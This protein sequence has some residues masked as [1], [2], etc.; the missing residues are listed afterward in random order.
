[1]MLLL[2]YLHLAGFF[3]F[4][5]GRIVSGIE[6]HHLLPGIIFLTGILSAFL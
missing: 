3:D 5:A 2:G 4:I 1:M 6:P